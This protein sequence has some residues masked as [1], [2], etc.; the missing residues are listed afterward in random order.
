[1]EGILI[2]EEQISLLG[3]MLYYSANHLTARERETYDQLIDSLVRKVNHLRSVEQRSSKSKSAAQTLS[4]AQMEAKKR[5]LRHLNA[6]EI[7]KLFVD[8]WNKQDFETEFFCLSKFFPIQKRKTDSV[9]EYVL[10][11]MQKYEDRHTIGPIAKRVV[12][13][14]SAQAHGNKTSVYCIELHKMPDKDLTLHREYELIFEEG[15]WR[16]AEFETIKSR[17]NTPGP[18]SHRSRV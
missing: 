1:M 8:S 10:H 12:E 6:E 2:E 16:I 13:I 9:Q 11:R 4:D 17:E 7:C 3:K 14:T 15:A 18:K 5:S